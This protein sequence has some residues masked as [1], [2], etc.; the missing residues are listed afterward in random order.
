MENSLHPSEHEPEDRELIDFLG[1]NT[2]P[3]HGIKNGLCTCVDRKPRLKLKGQ[4]C[5][6]PGKHPV[7]QGWKDDAEPMGEVFRHEFRGLNVG[8]RTGV[9]IEPGRKL[10]VVDGDSEEGCRW[11]E[12]YPNVKETRTNVTSRGKQYLFSVP[13]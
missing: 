9:E 1:V 7:E 5:D 4:N 2:F 3:V 12:S 10:V 11:I 6:S 13:P 8:I